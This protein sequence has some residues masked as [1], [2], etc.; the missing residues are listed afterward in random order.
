MDARDKLIEASRGR[1]GRIDKRMLHARG[2]LTDNNLFG[3]D[4]VNPNPLGGTELIDAKGFSA[5][6]TL[7]GRPYWAAVFWSGELGDRVQLR[8]WDAEEVTA[9][10][11]MYEGQVFALA[12]PGS[13]CSLRLDDAASIL[14]ALMSL[15]DDFD[16]DGDQPPGYLVAKEGGPG[17]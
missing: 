4:E 15:S 16:W 14:T 9:E 5:T 17:A 2:V 1:D 10:L 7:N 12:L 11:H 13:S 3:P 8:G 6:G